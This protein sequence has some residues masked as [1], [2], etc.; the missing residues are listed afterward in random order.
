[1]T[2]PDAAQASTAAWIVRRAAAEFRPELV[3]EPE[4]ETNST[5][6]LADWR[7]AMAVCASL[8][9]SSR[10]LRFV[11]PSFVAP[12]CQVVGVYDIRFLRVAGSGAG[13]RP[14]GRA[15][16]MSWARRADCPPSRRRGRS[17]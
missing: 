5:L 4:E 3:S 7:A 13:R 1:M 11:G 2:P 17:G 16:A 8:T 9:P 10:W 14:Q 15:P 12:S 6:L